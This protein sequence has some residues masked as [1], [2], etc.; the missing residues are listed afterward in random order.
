MKAR[1]HTEGTMDSTP[2][3]FN[4]HDI[5][6]LDIIGQ[7]TFGKVYKG[8]VRKTGEIVAV[9]KVYQDPKYKNR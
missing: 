2:P 9:K 1:M 4:S 3:M 5:D 8:K 7:G 6:L